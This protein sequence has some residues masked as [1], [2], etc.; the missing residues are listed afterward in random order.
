MKK[1]ITTLLTAAILASCSSKQNPNNYSLEITKQDTTDLKHLK[2]TLWPTSYHQGKPEMLDQILHEYF[3]M[4]GHSGEVSDKRFELE[5]VKNNHVAP[6]SFY[7]EIKRLDIFNN[8]TAVIAGTGHVFNDSTK[9][10]YESSN[11]LIKENGKW[12]AI[13]SHVS[14]VK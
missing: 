10:T 3:E 6:D 13:L 2:T 1:I 12:K 5:W 4:I 8:G 14:G 9:S 7:Y 11:V